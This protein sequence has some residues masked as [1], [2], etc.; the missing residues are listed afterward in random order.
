MIDVMVLAMQC[1]VTR[2]ITYMRGNGGSGRGGF[3]PGVSEGHHDLSHHE[4]NGY[5]LDPYAKVNAWDV[6]QFAYLVQRLAETDDGNGKLIDHVLAFYSSEI[7]DGN[8]HNHDRL[9]VL[10]AGHANG[11]VPGGRYIVAQDRTPIANLFA[12]MTNMVGAG[13]RFADSTGLLS[14]L[15]V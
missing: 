13:D 11:K 3:A 2:V 12:T 7:G 4:D 9:P 8:A 1:D 14:A 6:Q 10:L 15:T 5:K